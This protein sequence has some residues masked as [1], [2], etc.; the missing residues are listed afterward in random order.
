LHIIGYFRENGYGKINGF[1]AD[2]KRER[3]IRN[4][5]VISRLNGLGI[6]I[7]SDEVADIAGKKIFGRPHIAAAMIKRGVVPTQASAFDEYLSGGRKAY[8]GKRSLPPEECVSAIK[9]AGGLPVIAHPGMIGLRMK[10][11]AALAKS[12][13]AS[14]L[15]GIEAYYPEHTETATANY[16]ALAAALGLTATGGSDFHGE[17]RKRIRLGSGKNGGLKVP[18]DV[19]GI[20]LSSLAIGSG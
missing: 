10:N 4:L 19:P 12:L 16:V 14:G 15:F 1:L 17:Y 13:T 11:L 6:K 5:G 7:T 20:I 8:V 3:H 18:D 2:M 9:A